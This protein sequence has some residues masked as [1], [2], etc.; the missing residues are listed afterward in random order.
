MEL[1]AL[2]NELERQKTARMD[3]IV[4]PRDIF[5]QPDDTDVNLNFLRPAVIGDNME[6]MPSDEMEV[7]P[8]TDWGHSQL[9]NK[10]DIPLKYYRRM[11]EHSPELL[12]RNINQWMPKKDTKSNL[13]LRTLDGRVRAVLS[14]RYKIL[15][16]H[17]LL[18]NCLEEFRNMGAEL[19]KAD[20][21]ESHMYIK[22]IVPHTKEEIRQGDTVIPGVIVQNSEVGSGAFKVTPFM[23]RE[24]CSNG[25]I[26]E[27]AITKIHLGRKQDAGV[28]QFSQETMVAEG[29]TLGLQIRDIIRGTFDPV[30]FKQWV[31]QVRAGTEVE[32]QN[33]IYAIDNVMESFGIN[34]ALKED[35]LNHFTKGADTTQWGLANAVTRTARDLEDPEKVV[36]LEAIGGQIAVM[37][38][39]TLIPVVA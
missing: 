21:T 27:S 14:D 36:E 39:K 12:A 4:H 22:A 9:S 6:Q 10:L 19:H 18:L 7:M 37:P 1:I 28:V 11:R 34:D 23:L 32:I 2:A 17:D 29:K 33:P 38:A 15:D 25:M 16:N 31:Q 30:T 35:L 8:L 5:A 24:V 3:F 20:L 26:G 13:L